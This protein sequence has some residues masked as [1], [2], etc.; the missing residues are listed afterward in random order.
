MNRSKLKRTQICKTNGDCAYV[1]AQS[2]GATIQLTRCVDVTET[3]LG[4]SFTGVF[5]ALRIDFY[6]DVISPYSYLVCYP[7]LLRFGDVISNVRMHGKVF[8]RH[9]KF[10]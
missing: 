7:F 3:P 9:L 5:V 2:D 4:K 6:Y 1:I 10:S 8:A